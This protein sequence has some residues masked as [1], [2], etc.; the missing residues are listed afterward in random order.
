MCLERKKYDT[1]SQQASLVLK[2][3]RLSKELELEARKIRAQSSF[4][5]GKLN[6]SLDD[7]KFMSKNS[8][9]IE[10]AKAW[11]YIANIQLAD[12]NTKM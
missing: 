11:Y 2:S 12:K 9:S 3:E 6:E 1:A 7:F 10:G 4:E 8:A 5:L